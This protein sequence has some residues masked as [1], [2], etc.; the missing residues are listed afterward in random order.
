MPLSKLLGPINIDRMKAN[1]YVL[2]KMLQY[3]KYKSSI[4]WN[5]D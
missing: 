5:I 2:I 1:G 3:L 4:N